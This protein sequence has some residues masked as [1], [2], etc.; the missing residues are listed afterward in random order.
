MPNFPGRFGWKFPD[1]FRKFEELL[2]RNGTDPP[3]HLIAAKASLRKDKDIFVRI[4]QRWVGRRLPAPPRCGRA[5]RRSFIPDDLAAHQ[6]A[7]LSHLLGD[8]TIQGDIRFASQVCNVDTGAPSRD[9]HTID[10]APNV[11]EKSK[12]FLKRQILI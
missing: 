6:E 2:L 3:I 7:E 8:Q 4:A 11:S 12:I 9:E 1:R 10:F 5:R